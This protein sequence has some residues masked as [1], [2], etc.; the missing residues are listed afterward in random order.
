MAQGRSSSSATPFRA[1]QNAQTAH[2]SGT[3]NLYYESVTPPE[4]ALFIGRLMRRE[5]AHGEL[6]TLTTRDLDDINHY[7]TERAKLRQAA[8]QRVADRALREKVVRDKVLR[9][10]IHA[11]GVQQTYTEQEILAE[12]GLDQLS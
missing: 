4:I 1:H 5:L 6:S 7:L 9:S 12:F 10:R 11:V 8:R 3:H 2:A